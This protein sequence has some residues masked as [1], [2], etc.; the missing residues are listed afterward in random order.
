MNNFNPAQELVA[1]VLARESLRRAKEAGGPK[2]WSQDPLFQKYKWCNVRRLDDRVSRFLM[3]EWY[4]PDASDRTLVVASVLARLVN[5]PDSLAE[6]TDGGRFNLSHLAGAREA[7]RARKARG[8]KLFTAAYVVPGVPGMAKEDSV[9]DIADRVALY[10]GGGYD[11]G[12]VRAGMAATWRSLSGFVGLGSFLAGQAVADLAHL[13]AG[14]AW[15]DRD[16]WAPL[17]PGSSRG[18]NR[19]MER[20]LNFPVNQA[21]FDKEL[22]ALIAL[23]SPVLDPVIEDR[24]LQAMDFQNCLCEYDKYVRL[25]SGEGRVRSGYP[26]TA[27]PPSLLSG[28]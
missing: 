19:V 23:V 8:E 15:A 7:L 3:D 27:E 22:P 2:P 13:P 26:G 16:S 1:W 21:R 24:Q 11:F 10:Y 17:G 5:W 12:D 4:D 25:S 18:L 14:I 20:P 28:F 9:C 6:I